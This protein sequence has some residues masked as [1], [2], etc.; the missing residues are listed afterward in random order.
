MSF[1]VVH[2][3]AIIATLGFFALLIVG[4]LFARS[5]KEF[6]RHGLMFA[7][8]AAGFLVSMATKP[9]RPARSDVD[10]DF[11]SDIMLQYVSG[12]YYTLGYWMNGTSTWKATDGWRSTEWEPLSFDM[13]KNGKA[14]IL[15]V[16][17]NNELT[18]QYVGYY[19]DGATNDWVTIGSHNYT[20]G[21]DCNFTVGNLT[22]SDSNAN[23]IVW[24]DSTGLL[25]AWVDGTDCFNVTNIDTTLDWDKWTMLGMG[26]FNGD[27]KDEVLMSLNLESVV[28]YYSVGMDDVFTE[29][30][31]EPEIGSGW[32]IIAI[33]D[34]A[35][36]AKDDIV[37]YYAESGLVGLLSDGKTAGWKFLGQMDPSWKVVRVGDYDGDRKEDLLLHQ[38]SGGDS[39]GYY[40]AGD[41]SKWTTVG[42]GTP[43]ST[44]DVK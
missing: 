39:I 20:I 35:G 37:L 42:C 19:K 40:S 14:D 12:D 32:E 38:V 6:R 15:V 11:K 2:S 13:D 22:G 44:W 8:I 24:H 16:Q 36:D 4:L 18:E 10:G 33:G 29:L 28:R 41:M 23:S 27:G 17:E 34:F 5:A 30:F 9:T 21:T 25:S 43:S 26:D 31:A 1:E 3:Y 7:L